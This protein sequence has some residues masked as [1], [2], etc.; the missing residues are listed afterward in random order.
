MK[1][2]SLQRTAIVVL[3]PAIAVIAGT[4]AYSSRAAST[5]RE[6]AI[7]RDARVDL[8][9]ADSLE[10]TLT[11]RTPNRIS[12][13]EAIAALY[14][15][16]LRLGFGSPFRLIDQ[17]LRDSSLEPV[18]A[19][20]VG[21]A[22]LA[23]VMVGDAYRP[24]EA[25][26]D[27]M[28]LRGDRRMAA[29]HQQLIDS[30]VSSTPDPR[31]GELTVRLAYRLASASG[32][33]SRRAP[34][35]ATAAAAQARDR[36]IAM[37][38]ARDLMTEAER[39]G[40]GRLQLMRLWRSSRRFAVERPIIVPL[41]ARQERDAVAD[42][43]TLVAQ[44]TGISG[45]ADQDSTADMPR[46]GDG[47]P[48]RMA[49]V[50]AG[51]DL[52]PL[53]PVMVAVR[54]YSA[55]L[56][57][58]DGFTERVSKIR[59]VQRA[60]NEETLAAEYAL[61]ASRSAQPVPEADAA[62]LTAGVAM[63]PFAQE[64]AW[65][66]GDDAPTTRDLQSRFGVTVT[67]DATT[68]ASWRPYL[69]RTLET[70]IADMRRVLPGFDSRGLTVH[71]GTSP[72]GD[73]ALALH[74]PTRRIIYFPPTSH[75]GVMAHEFAHDLDWQAARREYGGT[76]W[77]RTDHALR[78]SVD[79]LAGALRQMA[80]ASRDS[81]VGRMTGNAR[82]TE[83]LARNVDWF[84]SASLAREGRVNGH[85]S[86]AQD[87]VLTGYASAIT[88]EA[89]RSG[90]SATLRALG[91]LT[92]IPTATRSWFSDLYGTDRRMTVHEA[93]R[94]VLE[95]PIGR[96]SVESNTASWRPGELGLGISSRPSWS[97]LA[98]EF[99]GDSEDANAVRA[100]IQYA[101][102]S[103]ARGV[104]RQWADFARRRPDASP[105]RLRALTGAPWDPSIAE[106]T[107]Q[108]IRDAILQSALEGRD[109]VG[110]RVPV[111]FRVPAPSC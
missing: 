104:V 20:A 26:M 47:L 39:D 25:A 99:A 78:Q 108:D 42:L 9:F 14:F 70:A 90:G 105:S 89:A 21:E 4:V 49:S 101:A 80:S 94:R 30:V 29:T 57:S 32:A 87:P 71:F 64:R 1:L 51:R 60:S 55:L 40:L 13:A 15:E 27:L 95:A 86:A 76:G 103:R 43:P 66:Q 106:Q 111:P 102:E 88:P 52:P 44:I 11:K 92:T 28:N 12:D 107:L 77:Y 24:R 75:S 72:L 10:R 18:G 82:P 62:V 7:M 65:L 53:A 2:R 61:L 59:F 31:V 36:I 98:N 74:D 79:L 83:V 100:V 63:R 91:G 96:L 81:S 37:R 46:R 5:K 97:C 56:R 3:L 54:S 33:V 48:S 67:Y 8:A 58:G 109:E 35:I 73:R 93:V 19:E 22:M 50:A 85:L 6:R 45:A 69:Q 110:D 38:D 68:H 17:A 23:R 34:E 84:V 16:R 41:T